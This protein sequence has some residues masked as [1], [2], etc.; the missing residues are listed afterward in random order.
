MTPSA[1]VVLCIVLAGAGVAIVGSCI[2]LH[3]RRAGG[4]EQREYQE[5]RL[6]QAPYLAEVRHRNQETIA[7]IYG[8][9]S[10]YTQQQH[11]SYGYNQSYGQGYGKHDR[12]PARNYAQYNVTQTTLPSPISSEPV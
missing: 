10:P 9:S 5:R 8:Y 4:N 11:D 6:E 1:V 2:F 3:T 7:A 12:R